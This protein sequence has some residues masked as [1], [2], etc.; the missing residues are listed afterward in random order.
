MFPDSAIAK[1][2]YRFLDKRCYKARRLEF[3]LQTFAFEHIGLSRNYHT[4]EIKRRLRASILELEEK[5]FLETLP[6]SE[7]F[8]KKERGVYTTP[9]AAINGTPLPNIS[10]HTACG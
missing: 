7:R 8:A 5:G 1:K 4:G 6:E 9:L 3:D 2:M 10:L